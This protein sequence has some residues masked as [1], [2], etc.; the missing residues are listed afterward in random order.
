[1][2]RRALTEQVPL[3]DKRCAYNQECTRSWRWQPNRKLGAGVDYR[4]RM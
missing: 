4:V 3:M 1:M 2:T